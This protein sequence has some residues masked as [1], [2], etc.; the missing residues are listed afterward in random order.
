M[1]ADLI[2]LT[3]KIFLEVSPAATHTKYNKFMHRSRPGFLATI[4][5]DEKKRIWAEQNGFLYVELNDAA[6]KGISKEIFAEMGVE[7]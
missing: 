3:S 4:K 6:I 7:L 5:R 1:R 2:N